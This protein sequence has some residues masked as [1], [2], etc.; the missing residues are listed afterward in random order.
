MV[1]M[2]SF[3][4]ALLVISVWAAPSFLSRLGAQQ[5]LTQVTTPRDSSPLLRPGDLVRLRIWREPDLSGDF[6]MDERG[7]IVFPKLGPVS[8]VAR[9]SAAL[10][11]TLVMAYSKYLRNPSIEVTLLR[12]VNVLGSVRNPG[13]YNV[14]PTMTL[15]DAL[16]MAGGVAPDGRADRLQLIRAGQREVLR[17][18]QRSRVADTPIEAG[19]QLYVPQRSWISRNPGMVAGVLGASASLV[20]I[21][22]R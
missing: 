5:Q 14:D 20:A 13:L 9:S 18:S 7:V 16:A 17:L 21:F 1:L 22:L 4:R 19:D 10:R 12:R 8:A 3:S 15:A 2:S 6:A 11:S